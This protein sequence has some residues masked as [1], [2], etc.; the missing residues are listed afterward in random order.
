MPAPL[1][2]TD[3]RIK[4]KED[5]QIL[6]VI[7]LLT[8]IIGAKCYMVITAVKNHS[9]KSKGEIYTRAKPVKRHY[10]QFWVRF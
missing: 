10:P 7:L 9:V 5:L 2:N 3:L 8:V 1:S 6:L 4:K